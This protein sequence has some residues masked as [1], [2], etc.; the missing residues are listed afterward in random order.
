MIKI[1]CLVDPRTNSPFYVGATM[2]KVKARLCS[3]I[4][5][6]SGYPPE[7]WSKKMQFVCEIIRS[8]EKPVA[9]TLAVVFL[10]D[11]D[12]YE[13]FFYNLLI[14]LG[15]K[16]LQKPHAFYYKSKRQT[17]SAKRSYGVF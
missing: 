12:Y 2:N 8:G 14:E 9:K 15:F 10:K 16:L 7:N 6:L 3:H 1:Y 17:D 4:S 11:V 13:S 5:E